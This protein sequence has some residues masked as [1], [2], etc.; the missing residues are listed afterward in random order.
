MPLGVAADIPYQASAASI[1]AGQVL[2]I[3][4]DG[5]WETRNPDGEFFGKQRLQQLIH[6]YAASNARTILL[7]IVDAVEE[8]RGQNDPEDDLTLLV[9]K[10]ND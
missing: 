10:V 7:S 9:V 2:F 1:E 3:G 6:R 8:F 4:T 5:I